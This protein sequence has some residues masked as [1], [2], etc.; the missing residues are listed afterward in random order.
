MEQAERA[1]RELVHD[2]LEVG[3]RPVLLE[4]WEV[5]LT[6]LSNAT[7]SARDLVCL[8]EEHLV[9]V[10]L[11]GLLG[12]RQVVLARE[13]LADLG[14]VQLRAVLRVAAVKDL[15]EPLRLLVD[16][17]RGVRRA[18]LGRR[19]VRRPHA[20]VKDLAPRLIRDDGVS[21]RPLHVCVWERLFF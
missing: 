1:V 18:R 11:D 20:D 7:N 16:L 12:E 9:A 2:E 5:V 10:V 4:A 3:K 6:S 13:V 14:D 15:L 21:E 8:L 17:L 19:P